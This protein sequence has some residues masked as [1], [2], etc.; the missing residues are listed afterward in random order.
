M[1]AINVPPESVVPPEYV[2]LPDK[3]NVPGAALTVNL[4]APEIVPDNVAANGFSV[5]VLA[6]VVVKV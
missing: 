4:F 1:P 6:P 2:L 5:S 3:L